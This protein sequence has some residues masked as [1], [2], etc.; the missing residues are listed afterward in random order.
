M[1]LVSHLYSRLGI[2]R[3]EEIS[4]EC[5]VNRIKKDCALFNSVVDSVTSCRNPFTYNNFDSLVNFSTG[6]AV[7]P[8]T[9]NFL[10]S[11]REKGNALRDDFI[12]R[13]VDDPAA[14]LKPL[15]KQKLMTFSSEG[16]KLKKRPRRQNSASE[17]GK[18]LDGQNFGNCFGEKGRYCTCFIV[19]SYA[20]PFMF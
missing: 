2:T 10:L 7:S 1:T 11:V 8:T 6:K 17:N 16:V 5:H 14:F 20:D 15:Q 3:K 9:Q 4:R 19:P 13:C 18:R 12:R